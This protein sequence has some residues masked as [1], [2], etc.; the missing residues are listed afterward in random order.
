[1]TALPPQWYAVILGCLAVLAGC[2]ASAV[3]FSSGLRGGSRLQYIPAAGAAIFVAGVVGQRTFPTAEELQRLGAA[4]ST[5]APGPWES[6]VHFPWIG[7]STTPVALAGL[8][9]ASLGVTLLLFFDGGSGEKAARSG[10]PAAGL[11]DD[12]SA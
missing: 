6:G 9:I 1:M 10:P 12:D 2:V 5:S 8:L 11:D 7:L 3:A 4:A